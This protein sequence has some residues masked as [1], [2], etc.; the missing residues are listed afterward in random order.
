MKY[1]GIFID[2]NLTWKHHIDHLAFKISRYVDLLSK[3]RHHVPTHTLI[4]IHRS[5]ISPHLTYG[6]LAW[7]QA[8]KS[9]L[10]KLLKLQKRALR[11]IYFS[12]FK[13]DAVPLFIQAGFFLLKCSFFKITTNLMY[14]VRH[15]IAPR[16]I[17]KQFLISKPITLDPLLQTIS[18]RKALDSQIH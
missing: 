16:R 17:Q 13:Q 8:C 4:T 3:L 14:D 6:L 12:D 15:K 1:L 7:A 18:I 10:E 9:H 2:Q 5:L 11:F